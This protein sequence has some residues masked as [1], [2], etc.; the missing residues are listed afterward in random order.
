M[1]ENKENVPNHFL[2]V[3]KIGTDIEPAALASLLDNH[4]PCHRSIPATG[5]IIVSK[6]LGTYS[7]FS[8]PILIDINFIVTAVKFD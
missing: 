7:Y 6:S 8:K 4:Q 5:Q 2:I 3:P 1:T